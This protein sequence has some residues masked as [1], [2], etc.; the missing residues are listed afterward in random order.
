[1]MR[2]IIPDNRIRIRRQAR[3]RARLSQ[4]SIMIIP[5]GNDIRDQESPI[6]FLKAV[7]ILYR[8]FPPRFHAATGPCHR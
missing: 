2:S 8:P 7:S 6:K 5:V 4:R 1:V 3:G